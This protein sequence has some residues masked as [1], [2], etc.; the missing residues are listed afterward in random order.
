MAN[1]R[2]FAQGQ[3]L[4]TIGAGGWA[5]VTGVEGL[6]IKVDKVEHKLGADNKNILTVGNPEW[7]DLKF[8]L[9]MVM[10]ADMKQWILDTI[11]KTKYSRRNGQLDYADYNFEVAA[12]KAFTEALIKKITLPK[13]EAKGKDSAKLQIEVAVEDVQ[14]AAGGGAKLQGAVNMQ[15]KT[16]LNNAFRMDIPGWP[17]DAVTSVDAYNIE[18]AVSK[19]WVGH[20]RHPTIEPSDLKYSD[21]KVTFNCNKDQEKQILDIAKKVMVDGQYDASADIAIALTYLDNS[22]KKEQGTVTFNGCFPTEVKK[23]KNESGKDNINQYDI[24]FAVTDVDLTQLK[25][26]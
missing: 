20:L 1:L 3:Y 12:S 15:Q 18:Q 16:W 19:N 24:T 6:D 26:S 10:G 21:L 22:R 11:Q 14:Y 7:T 17:Q 5:P 25:I 4:L 13:M 8:D 2:T 9:A 23:S